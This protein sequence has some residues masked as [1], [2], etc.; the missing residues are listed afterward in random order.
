MSR[1]LDVIRKCVARDEV[2]VPI[3]FL[4]AM[5]DD[6]LFWAD[7]LA[8]ID[9]AT[10]AIGD[11]TDAEGDPK[12]RVPGRALDRRKIEVVCAIKGPLVLVT[13]Y[14]LRSAR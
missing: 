6:G 12:Y 10:T 8:A 9:E 13:V 5:R 14:V 3:H 2:I 4:E 1:A 7:I 11:G